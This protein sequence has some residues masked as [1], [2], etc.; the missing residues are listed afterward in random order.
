M[1]YVQADLSSLIS[2]QAS[3][4]TSESRFRLS[5]STLTSRLKACQ[6]N[7][8]D[9]SKGRFIIN[10]PAT[11]KIITMLGSAQAIEKCQP[12]LK[13]ISTWPQKIEWPDFIDK[14]NQ[15]IMA[16]LG[17]YKADTSINTALFFTQFIQ[18][19]RRIFIN[20]TQKFHLF[21]LGLLAEAATNY[22]QYKYEY[23]E[24]RDAVNGLP[25]ARQMRRH[26]QETIDRRAS[27]HEIGLLLIHIKVAFSISASDQS[28]DP[29]L[30]SE[31]VRLIQQNLRHN[32]SLFYIGPTEFS[33]VLSNFDNAVKLDLLAAKLE[34]TFEEVLH[35]DRKPYSLTPTIA[36]TRLSV[37]EASPELIYSQARLTLDD[38]LRTGKRV[39]MFR[40]EINER[41]IARAKL[42]EQLI[43]A[44]KNNQLTLFLQPI[45]DLPNETCAGAEVLLRLQLG[46]GQYI[47]PVE[48]IETIYKHGLGRRFTRWLLSSVCRLN[49]EICD[50]LG[51]R[52]RL[53]VNLSAEDLHD[54]E[55]PHLLSQNLMLWAVNAEDIV[56]EITENELLVDE[57]AAYKI[58][59]QLV[60]LGCKL[61]LDDFGTGYSSMSRLRS[62]PINLVKIDQ[63]FV[64]NIANSSEDAEIVR[65][66][67]LL[68][69]GLGKEVV[70][71]GIEDSNCLNLIKEMKCQKVQGYYYSKPLSQ[72]DFCTWIKE[73]IS[74]QQKQPA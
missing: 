5:S 2:I 44:F 11:A 52:I 55:L 27:H 41:A 12:L 32:D 17:A 7:T 45:L 14:I 50:A 72:D 21:L 16:W 10:I 63:S 18:L 71:E 49:S 51:Q 26:I 53:T 33:I 69:H 57:E 20:N 23:M 56:L 60:Q 37:S 24:S 3:P 68:A 6:L 39:A 8:E 22:D 36:G 4:S 48:V 19:K 43:E 61:A 47:S 29:R 35:V 28:L 13:E 62:M 65:A 1:D 74:A 25:N 59:E 9:I 38:A 73:R 15:I 70:A 58:M 34:R 66:I 54:P 30:V 64:R 42:E 67:A 40:P 31:I 46:D